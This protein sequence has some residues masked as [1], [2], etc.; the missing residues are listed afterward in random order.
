LA[1]D[2]LTS[3]GN[4]VAEKTNIGQSHHKMASASWPDVA[5]QDSRLII[6]HG[7]DKDNDYDIAP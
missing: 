1:V 6:P 2:K 7:F 3:I 4:I 5:N